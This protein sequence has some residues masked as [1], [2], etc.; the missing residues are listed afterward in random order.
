MYYMLLQYKTH[1]HSVHH[2]LGISQLKAIG[3]DKTPPQYITLETE[4]KNPELK[5]PV[6][7]DLIKT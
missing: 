6:I 2:M 5:K 3:L 4:G 7:P 1:Q